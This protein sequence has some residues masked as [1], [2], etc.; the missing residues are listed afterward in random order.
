MA[1][2]N[3]SFQTPLLQTPS[4]RQAEDKNSSHKGPSVF[5]NPLSRERGQGHGSPADPAGQE[6]KKRTDRVHP[7]S[8]PPLRTQSQRSQVT[9]AEG[10]ARP[11]RYPEQQGP[12]DPILRDSQKRAAL[13][14]HPS[15]E[16]HQLPSASALEMPS[17]L[18]SSLWPG[19]MAL[20]AAHTNSLPTYSENTETLQGALNSPGCQEAKLATSQVQRGCY[21]DGRNTPPSSRPLYPKLFLQK[22]G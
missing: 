9:R 18:P 15:G 3:S 21:Q 2:G 22:L 16:G 6:Q 1:L 14:H 10:D 7:W 5:C 19:D 8:Q 11:K 20:D 13:V 12:R 17:S 4:P